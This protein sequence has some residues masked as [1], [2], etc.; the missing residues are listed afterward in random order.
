MHSDTIR[1]ASLLVTSLCI[2]LQIVLIIVFW[3]TEMHS[4]AG[5]YVHIAHKCYEAGEYYPSHSDLYSMYLVC[6]GLINWFVLQHNIFGTLNLNMLFNFLMSCGITYFIFRITKLYFSEAVG[7]MAILLWNILYSNW[8]VVLPALTEVPFLFLALG[9]YY[10]SL[11]Y[12]G[13]PAFLCVGIMVVLAN[14][15]RPLIIIFAIPMLLIMLFRHLPAK[16]Y[17]AMFFSGAIMLLAIAGLTYSK[18]GVPAI[19]SSTAGVNLIMTANDRAYGGVAANLIMSG[20]GDCCITDYETR[21]FVEKDSIY[22]ARAIEWIKNNPKRYAQL[23]FMKI[24][25]LWFED[26]WSDRAVMYGESSVGIS[27]TA[28]TE[29]VFNSNFLKPFAGRIAKSVVY[30]IILLIGIVG[31][32]SRAKRIIHNWRTEGMLILIL[33]LGIGITCIFAV[34]PRY[35]YPMLPIIVIFAAKFLCRRTS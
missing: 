2:V 4:D 1:K 8:M 34:C 5:D 13:W 30:Y 9:C 35:H 6:P 7:Y 28:T 27:R 20:Y 10:I 14:W 12:K 19:Q 23:Y 29:G 25:G 15:I 32:V 24:G 17:I 11:N 21:T 31:I 3:G 22:S 26:S 18:V 33:L 16:C